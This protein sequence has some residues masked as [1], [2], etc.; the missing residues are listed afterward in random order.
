MMTLLF[1]ADNYFPIIW[2][3]EVTK[4]NPG[5]FLGAT[6]VWNVNITL[7][8]QIAPYLWQD[9]HRRNALILDSGQV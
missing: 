6:W 3:S 9:Y 2:V 5:T 8:A 7:P 1:F 4:N